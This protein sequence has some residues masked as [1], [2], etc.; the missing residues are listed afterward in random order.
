MMSDRPIRIRNTMDEHKRPA[1]GYVDGIGI[2]INWQDGPLGAPDDPN[3]MDPN[4][5]FVEDVI[6][7]ALARLEFYQIGQFQCS[8]NAEAIEYLRGALQA[9]N[10]RTERRTKAGVEG[11]HDGN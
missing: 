11:T 8:E 5:A 3:R 1:G 7:I 4:G 2:S 6:R 9:L 10:H